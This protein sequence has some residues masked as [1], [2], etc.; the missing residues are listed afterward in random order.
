MATENQCVKCGGATQIGFVMD[1]AESNYPTLQLW[2]EGAPE[3]SFWSGFD[4][5]DRN[6]RFVDKAVRCADC[7]YLEFYAV[8]SKTDSLNR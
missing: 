1:K 4:T 5:S 6:L 3:K 2:V 8:N 7:G